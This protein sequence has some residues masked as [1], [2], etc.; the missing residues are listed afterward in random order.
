M[1]PEEDG[2]DRLTTSPPYIPSGANAPK[3]AVAAAVVVPGVCC[4]DDL[5]DVLGERGN[6][7]GE[8]VKLDVD[9]E[10]EREKEVC[11]PMAEKV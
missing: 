5:V 11:G 6:E 2:A 10:R 7:R 1:T 9:A 8:S 4:D 3:E